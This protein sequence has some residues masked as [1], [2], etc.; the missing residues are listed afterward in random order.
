M[1]E[2]I[3][4]MVEKTIMELPSELLTDINPDNL[5]VLP[6]GTPTVSKGSDGQPFVD[7]NTLVGDV[8]MCDLGFVHPSDG[9][10]PLFGALPTDDEMKDPQF[11]M[12]LRL[13]KARMMKAWIDDAHSPSGKTIQ[14]IVA[15]LCP[16]NYAGGVQ[17][18]ESQLFD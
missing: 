14:Q 1:T 5:M 10:N 18:Q 12:N 3:G 8:V 2:Q 9:G 6:A 15:P 13:F 16:W 17:H 7:S 4:E 11:E